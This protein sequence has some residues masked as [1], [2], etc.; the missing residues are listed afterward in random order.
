M[1]FEQISLL[2]SLLIL[3]TVGLATHY[4][5][6]VE[7]RFSVDI[8]APAASPA[9]CSRGAFRSLYNF[10]L[11][12]AAD[13]FTSWGFRMNSPYNSHLRVVHSGWPWSEKETCKVT[14]FWNVSPR[15]QRR[16]ALSSAQQS[17][18][19]WRE[20]APCLW[21]LEATNIS[22]LFQCLLSV[23][24][25]VLSPFLKI[26]FIQSLNDSII[27]VFFIHVFFYSTHIY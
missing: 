16:A 9:E 7:F 15:E 6:A 14:V 19:Y 21:H 2:C 1:L 25:F 12:P 5:I 3:K 4:R 27:F 10:F 13:Q 20:Q 11:T 26:Y 24:D 8:V 18:V 22:H 17:L 23:Y